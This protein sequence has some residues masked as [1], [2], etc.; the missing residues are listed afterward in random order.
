MLGF[1][2][3]HFCNVNIFNVSNFVISHEIYQSS[4]HM[5]LILSK[6]DFYM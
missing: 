6:S 5:Q 2:L 4:F 1:V 3:K